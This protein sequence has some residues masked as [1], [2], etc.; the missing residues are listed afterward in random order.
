MSE[1]ISV[2]DK[3]LIV[4]QFEMDKRITTLEVVE[5]SHRKE[6]HR[7]KQHCLHDDKLDCIH[8]SGVTGAFLHIV[9]KCKLCKREYQTSWAFLSRK[10]R[11]GLRKLGVKI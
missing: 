4:N 11:K 2:R 10:E 3:R 6:I 1:E 9:Y 8:Y 5:N 7:L